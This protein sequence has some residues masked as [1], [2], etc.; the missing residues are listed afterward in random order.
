[1]SKITEEHD[2][3]NTAT[4]PKKKRVKAQKYLAEMRKNLDLQPK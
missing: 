4:I 1:M 2:Y 3:L